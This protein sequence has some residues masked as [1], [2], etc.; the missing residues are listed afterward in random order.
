MSLQDSTGTSGPAVLI[1]TV[2]DG[3]AAVVGVSGSL[4]HAAAGQFDRARAA[5]LEEPVDIVIVNLSATMFLGS[6][7]MSALLA[8]HQQMV[9]GSRELVV[10]ADGPAT[11]MPLDR[12]GLSRT[13]RVVDS[14]DTAL[15]QRRHRCDGEAESTP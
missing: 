5:V 4:D 3:L 15:H 2:S 12:A 9:A 1:S 14:L 6:A 8:A 11:A 13:L 7:A 10:V